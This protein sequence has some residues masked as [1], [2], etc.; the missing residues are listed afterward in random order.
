MFRMLKSSKF[1]ALLAQLAVVLGSLDMT[2]IIAVLPPKAAAVMTV[3]AGV[4]A[5]INCSVGN[6]TPRAEPFHS[7]V[8]R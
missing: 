4:V 8:V 1:V 6:P 2:G 5:M 3:V 7:T